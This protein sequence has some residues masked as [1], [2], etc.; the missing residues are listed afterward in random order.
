VSVLHVE[1][2]LFAELQ[3]LQLHPQIK[4]GPEP[5]FPHRQYVKWMEHHTVYLPNMY[6]S[7]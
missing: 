2:Q 4:L 1:L 7:G 5:A 6:T 3:N